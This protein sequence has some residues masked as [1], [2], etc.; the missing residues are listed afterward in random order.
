M[1]LDLS[2]DE[3]AA[4]TKELDDITRNRY[5]FSERI[6]RLKAAAGAALTLAADTVE[7]PDADSDLRGR[8]VVPELQIATA[9][10]R[11]R[12]SLIGGES[13]RSATWVGQALGASD[14]INYTESLTGTRRPRELTD[15]RGVDC[16]VEIGGPSAIVMS[17]SAL[18]VDFEAMNRTIA[19]SSPIAAASPAPSESSTTPSLSD[20]GRRL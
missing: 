15:G 10:H 11:L 1:N 14:V 20:H 18:A 6:R 2:N 9:G 3:T 5:P 16:I 12:P 17:L 13:E 4:L 8:A 19:V 7:F